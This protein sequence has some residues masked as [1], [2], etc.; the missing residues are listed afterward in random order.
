MGCS[1]GIERFLAG[2]WDDA[3]A[4]LESSLDLAE[5]IGET[6]SVIFAHIAIALICFHRDDLARADEAVQTAYREL[7]GRGFRYRTDWAAWPHALLQ[8]ASGDSAQALETMTA[9]WE[10]SVRLGISMDHPVVGADLVR[11]AMAGGDT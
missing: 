1:L 4:E 6:H 5:E 11:L 2:E 7:I 8:E 10:E 3:L 9:P